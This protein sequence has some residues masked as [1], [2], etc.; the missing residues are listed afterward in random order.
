MQGFNLAIQLTHS[1][2]HLKHLSCSL[3]YYKMMPTILSEASPSAVRL[4]ILALVIAAWLLRGQTASR[5]KMNIPHVKFEGDNSYAR[6]IAEAG[7]LMRDG[8][9]KVSDPVCLISD[10]AP[11]QAPPNH[12]ILFTNR[13]GSISKKGSLLPFAT[14]RMTTVHLLCCPQNI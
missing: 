1:Q 12:A 2:S 5:K 4:L 7:S 8:Y 9:Y 6:Y 13:G 11:N 10:P 14:S 3:L